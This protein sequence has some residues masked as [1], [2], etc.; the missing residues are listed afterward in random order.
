MNDEVEGLPGELRIASAFDG[1]SNFD[2]VC[3][4]G[5]MER[6]A[7]PLTLQPS[8]GE[9]VVLLQQRVV[10]PVAGGNEQVQLDRRWMVAGG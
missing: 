7:V 8:G 6:G 4:A 2:A 3:T 1:R 9:A 5:D 10:G